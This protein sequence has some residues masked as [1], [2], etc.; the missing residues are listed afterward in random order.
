MLQ[1]ESKDF[2]LKGEQSPIQPIN[3]PVML[4]YTLGSVAIPNRFIRLGLIWKASRMQSFSGKPR[5]FHFQ[6][7]CS[8]SL[9]KLKMSTIF[10]KNGISRFQEIFLS[11]DGY[12][13][14]N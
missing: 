5:Y 10:F 13:D 8:L 6:I 4:T 9:L 1:I 14:N 11:A 7:F 12:E 2:R 3:I